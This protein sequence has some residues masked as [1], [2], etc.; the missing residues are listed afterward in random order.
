MRSFVVSNLGSADL[1]VSAI[2]S[3]APEFSGSIGS[4]LL[5]PGG[6][7]AVT[8]SFAP[9]TVGIFNATLTLT[10]NDPGTP[11]LA[12][13]LVGTAVTAP[14]ID[15]SPVLLSSTL[16][17]GQQEV[18][19]LTIANTGGSPLDFS[20]SAL[21]AGSTTMPFAGLSAGSEAGDSSP[22]SRGKIVALQNQ[23]TTF[24]NRSP[25]IARRQ[26]S[27]PLTRISSKPSSQ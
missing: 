23:F 13:A 24:R 7:E 12:I 21:P 3:D 5:P 6:R 15:V 11:Q 10:S 22:H 1:T 25:S 16:L 20:L 18:Q 2:A 27:A 19:T 9:T 26:F 14:V 4:L 17:D 8:V